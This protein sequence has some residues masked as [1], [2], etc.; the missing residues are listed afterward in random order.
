[1]GA[2]IDALRDRISDPSR[3][4][5]INLGSVL[6]IEGAP[7]L[8][9]GQIALIALSCARTLSGSSSGLALYDAL[10]ADFA[11]DAA[12]LNAAQTAASLM[13]M[14]NVYYRF[15]HLVNDEEIGRLPARLRMSAM[16]SPGVEKVDFELACLAISAINGCGMCMESHT[17]TLL[18]HTV[19]RTAIQSSVRIAAVLNAAAAALR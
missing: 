8:S 12:V 18:Q 14:N 19:T 3:D 5:R 11:P 6:T 16:A 17:K 15:V 1:M 2:A 7:D 9:V 4:T 13:A 10:V